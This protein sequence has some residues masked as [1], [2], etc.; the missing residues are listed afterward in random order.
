MILQ[1]LRLVVAAVR[2][3][4]ERFRGPRR[5]ELVLA[6]VTVIPTASTHPTHGARTK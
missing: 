5:D 4:L 1:M 2:V 3:E 6:P